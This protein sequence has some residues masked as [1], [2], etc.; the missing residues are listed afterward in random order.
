MKNN[1]PTHISSSFQ[2]RSQD[3]VESVILI[4]EVLCQKFRLPSPFLVEV[5]I[6]V[7][8]MCTISTMNEASIRSSRLFRLT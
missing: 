1:N 4:E 7:T 8:L 5:C 6:V 2:R 3:V